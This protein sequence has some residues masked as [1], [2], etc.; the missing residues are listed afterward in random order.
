MFLNT[1]PPFLFTGTRCVY[2]SDD[3][4]TVRM[5][6]ARTI[7]TRNIHGSQFGGA[8]FAMTD[9]AYALMLYRILGS[10]HQVW[11]KSASIRFLR[12]GRTALTAEFVITDEDLDA[13]ESALRSNGRTTH[14]FGVLVK[15]RSGETVADVTVEVYLKG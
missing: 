13:I 7:L 8:I 10:R 11:N 14:T 3:Y 4:R 6:L 5:R 2:V 15:D 9:P 1:Y 12:P